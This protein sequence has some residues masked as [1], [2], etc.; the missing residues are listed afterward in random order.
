MFP[1]RKETRNNKKRFTEMF[2]VKR[3]NAK[4]L[5]KSFIPYMQKLLNEN[6]LE[7]IVKE[8]HADHPSCSNCSS[9]LKL[10]KTYLC[11]PAF[12]SCAITITVY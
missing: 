7:K 11:L 5:M 1:I 4:C 3:A 9:E 2:A 6:Y 10:W 12:W 8:A